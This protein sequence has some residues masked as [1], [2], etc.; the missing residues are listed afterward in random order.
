M[1]ELSYTGQIH[2]IIGPMYSGKTTELLRLYRRHQIA[3]QKCIL[4]KYSDDKRFDEDKVVSHDNLK[5]DAIKTSL[6]S[7]IFHNPSILDADVI[8]IDEIQF[9]TDAHIMCDMWANNGK[10]V[11]AAGLNGDY[12]REPFDIISQLLP[13][14]ENITFLTAICKKTSS[15]GA[16][17]KRI[18]N[19]TEV[20][21]IGGQESYIASSRKEHFT[22]YAV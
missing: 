8:C 16:F 14:V 1:S 10:I 20:K 15:T 3:N 2:L 12:K 5:Y 21:L 4:I 7:A 6:L 13:K 22:T 17:T 11:I 9:Y 18:T 19:D